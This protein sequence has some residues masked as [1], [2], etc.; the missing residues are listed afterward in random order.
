MGLLASSTSSMDYQLL[1]FVN[2]THVQAGTQVPFAATSHLYC[3]PIC[4]PILGRQNNI[5]SSFTNLIC[6]SP[7]N[8]FSSTITDVVSTAAI[9]SGAIDAMSSSSSI[10]GESLSPMLD[11]RHTSSSSPHL[12]NIVSNGEGDNG[13]ELSSN[14]GGELGMDSGDSNAMVD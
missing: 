10:H 2:R 12:D 7:H 8:F 9:S 4:D 3:L 14:V 1:M 13:S 6:C 5:T 11:A